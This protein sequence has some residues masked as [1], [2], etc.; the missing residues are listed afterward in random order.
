MVALRSALGRDERVEQAEEEQRRT[1]MDPDWLPLH[2][3][4]CEL[5]MSVST[6]RRMIRRG[7][8]RN[9]II[10]RRG[11]FQY[12][13][14]VPNSRHASLLTHPC[15]AHERDDSH[16]PVSL[17]AYRRMRHTNA[18]LQD[19]PPELLQRDLK[20]RRLEEQVE[21]LSEALNREHRTR[22]KQLPVGSGE[23][24]HA[25]DP[26]ARYRWL[27]RRKRWWPF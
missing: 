24:Q 22:Q 16:A 3:A 11:G 15:S 27:V 9:R 7:K 17:D 26:Y 12:L 2:Q 25:E 1:S 13:I 23:A 6:A 8:L 10:P 20:I 4:A 14:Y 5:G 18:P 21:H 19:A